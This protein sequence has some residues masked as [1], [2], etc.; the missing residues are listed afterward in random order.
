MLLFTGCG[1][2][3]ITITSDK[4]TEDNNIQSIQNIL[5]SPMILGE[6]SAINHVN[7][8][9]DLITVIENENA[10]VSW[11]TNSSDVIST[12]G[13]VTQFACLSQDENV[14]L[15]ATIG[16]DGY[17]TTK[18]FSVV[19]T[20]RPEVVLNE[21]SDSSMLTEG[22]TS[23]TLTQ[24]LTIPA[25][26]CGTSLWSSNDENVLNSQSGVVTQ[27]VDFNDKAIALDINFTLDN[28]AFNKRFQFTVLRKNALGKIDLLNTLK[29]KEF[30]TSL[31]TSESC[32]YIFSQT[33]ENFVQQCSNRSSNT[34][35]L[36]S[37]LNDGNI[38]V[39]LNSTKVGEII[40]K[41]NTELRITRTS[42]DELGFTNSKIT[43]IIEVTK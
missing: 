4:E 29:A 25:L 33:A 7:R 37:F 32:N 5:T 12:N 38:D 28:E 36:L 40:N 18:T 24:N 10:T 6:N 3:D 31:T 35:F 30:N 20:T 39:E 19:V 34:T 43:D 21:I 42:G 8:D 23:S 11:E 13:T 22:Q 26:S 27:P 9:L 17:S 14:T 41:S 1:E 15:A 2:S 16:K